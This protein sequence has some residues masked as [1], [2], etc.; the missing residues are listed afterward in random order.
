MIVDYNGKREIEFDGS[1]LE[2]LEKLDINP[3]TAVVVRDGR[4]LVEQ[5]WLDN[6]NEVEILKVR[7]DAG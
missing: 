1:V 4:I 6:E 5:D 7:S 3:V 2:L